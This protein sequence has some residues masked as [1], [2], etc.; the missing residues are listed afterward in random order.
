MAFFFK[1]EVW[2]SLSADDVDKVLE[3]SGVDRKTWKRANRKMAPY[4]ASRKNFRLL[5]IAA[6]FVAGIDN[7]TFDSLTHA[8]SEQLD[9]W[10]ANPLLSLSELQGSASEKNRRQ[11][12]PM[13]QTSDD[14]PNLTQLIR[15]YIEQEVGLASAFTLPNLGI[16]R[17]TRQIPIDDPLRLDLPV[18]VVRRSVENRYE[19]QGI[20]FTTTLDALFPFLPKLVLLG[21]AQTGKSTYV[22]YLV[23]H[24]GTRFLKSCVMPDEPIQEMDK[25]LLPIR[26]A[27]R[28]FRR[29]V[30]LP[31]SG[32]ELVL[33][34][35]ARR[36]GNL[37]GTEISQLMRN[38]FTTGRLML[39]IDGL[40]ELPSEDRH[41]FCELI[42]EMSL[43]HPNCPILVTSWVSAF[44][45]QRDSLMTFDAAYIN[46]IPKEIADGFCDRIAQNFGRMESHQ[47]SFAL[48][49]QSVFG[50]VLAAQCHIEGT[51]TKDDFEIH[52]RVASFLLKKRRFDSASSVQES[53]GNLARK[54]FEH[55]EH[56]VTKRILGQL[57]PLCS[58]PF[59]KSDILQSG[60]LSPVMAGKSTDEYEFVYQEL[61][62]YFAATSLANSP[63]QDPSDYFIDICERQI[64]DL[65]LVVN[66]TTRTRV[67]IVSPSFIQ[68]FNFFLRS[69]DPRNAAKLG[70]QLLASCLESRLEPQVG[71]QML[72]QFVV[73]S[74]VNSYQQEEILSFV[75]NS[76]HRFSSW[77]FVPTTPVDRVFIDI[78]RK[79]A[80]LLS[81]LVK[82]AVRCQPNRKL[83]RLLAMLS[84]ELPV[85][86]PSSYQALSDFELLLSNLRNDRLKSEEFISNCLKHVHDSAIGTYFAW[87]AGI[88]IPPSYRSI[89]VF[90][91]SLRAQ[92]FELL[93][94]PNTVHET[95]VELSRIFAGQPELPIR[96]CGLR[97]L[98]TD[99]RRLAFCGDPRLRKAFLDRFIQL[100]PGSWTR[101]RLA[102]VLSSVGIFH[103]QF[104]D[105]LVQIATSSQYTLEDAQTAIIA[106]ALTDS[107]RSRN[108]VLRAQ[109]T[110]MWDT[111]G[112]ALKL[113]DN[114]RSK[115]LSHPDEA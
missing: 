44:E 73:G 93:L 43:I 25:L 95:L 78:A 20:R 21:E 3:I 40:D 110:D 63:P 104:I 22:S 6:C 53:I 2:E 14:Y 79:N 105:A 37:E 30:D 29:R 50:L 88:A 54:L 7:E 67:S 107:P 98:P 46:S 83:F 59:E 16:F 60:I 57:L 31:S 75:V 55:G 41:D 92:I 28:E 36:V 77:G 74:I 113:I 32:S 19:R 87:L 10:S 24:F 97:D 82:I 114:R 72:L 69:I 56:R 90:S 58:S 26:V 62:Y 65:E 108:A 27:C 34:A 42:G 68:T 52:D 18:D 38:L 102:L 61:L 85:G 12:A 1:E 99:L 86:S 80:N 89:D 33:R 70:D 13:A 115:S 8:S 100:K 71:S 103:E 4:Y 15:S 45:E 84:I 11:Q 94:D 48:E 106:L 64:S 76:L 51:E 5:C 23:Y 111:V 35:I 109:S 66:A 81:A 96:L 101:S 91:P 49:H 9:D 17:R 47:S 39:L 112:V